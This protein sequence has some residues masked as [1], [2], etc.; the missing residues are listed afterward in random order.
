[1][2]RLIAALLLALAATS[3]SAVCFVHPDTGVL[4]CSEPTS[5]PSPTTW[6]MITR[7][8]SMPG[9]P[10]VAECSGTDSGTYTPTPHGLANL[11][12]IEAHRAMW[13]R[14]KGVV[15][16]AGAVSLTPVEAGPAF[17]HLTVPVAASFESQFD[18]SGT[19]SATYAAQS[20]AVLGLQG[21]SAARFYFV[22]PTP[23][24]TEVMR[25]VYSY[26]L[27]GC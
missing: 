7:A 13:T 20:R 2:N 14:I 12:A 11:G 15:T 23:D 16:V 18:L 1:M 21:S 19:M 22:A 6:N 3:A 26:S 5:C 24:A 17:F 4:H 10:V 9:P 27:P 25:Y 8:C